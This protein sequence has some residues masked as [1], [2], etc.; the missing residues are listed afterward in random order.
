MAAVIEAPFGEPRGI[1]EVGVVGS[2]DAAI[3]WGAIIGGAVAAVAVTFILVELGAGL[4]LAAVSPWLQRGP[5]PTTFA[6]TTAIWLILVQWI[7]AGFG[8]YVAGRLRTKWVGVHT[9]EVFFRDTAH[10]FLS[11]ALATVTGAIIAGIVAMAAISGAVNTATTVASAGVQA[12][13]QVAAPRSNGTDSSAYVVDTM[14]RSNGASSAAAGSPAPT[15]G[16]VA[17]PRRDM[18]GEAGRILAN[19]LSSGDVTP[20]DKTYLAQIVATQTGLSPPD[21]Q[22]RVDDAIAQLQAA[23]AKAQIAADAAR[24]AA[25]TTA[26]MLALS[27]IVGAFIASTAGAIGGHRRDSY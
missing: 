17:S 25:A 20:D 12:A 24:K 4:G 19:D 22:K 21:A 13:G 15:D 2:V 23:K 1:S 6:I 7:A 5:S 11:W 14:F 3:S 8:G 26:M 27:M 10:G 9:D 18:R 16:A